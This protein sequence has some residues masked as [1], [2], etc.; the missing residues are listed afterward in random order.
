MTATTPR[1]SSSG[2]IYWIE[3]PTNHYRVSRDGRTYRDCVVRLTDG[4]RQLWA[5]PA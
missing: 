2:V 5:V 1:R 3:E 4:R